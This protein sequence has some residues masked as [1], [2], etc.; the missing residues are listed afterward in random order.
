[1]KQYKTYLL[2]AVLLGF[3]EMSFY[4]FGSLL[5]YLKTGSVI[6]TLFFGLTLKAV[7]LVIKSVLVRPF[8]KMVKRL[9][10]IRVMVISVFIWGTAAVSLFLINVHSPDSLFLFFLAGVVY[11]TA[12]SCY[13][14]LSNAF[15]FQFIGSSNIPPPIYCILNQGR[16]FGKFIYCP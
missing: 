11:A 5:F 8:L 16:P 4:I 14:M 6:S 12:H 2:H 3:T 13:W 7:A 9:G 15:G 10:V 1:M